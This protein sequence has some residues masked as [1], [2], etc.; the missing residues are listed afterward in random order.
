[1]IGKIFERRTAFRAAAIIT[2][3][4]VLVAAG[5]AITGLFA[6]AAILPPGSAPT[7]ASALFALYAATRTLPLA[8]FALVAIFLRAIPALLILGGLAGLVQFLDAGVGLVQGDVGKTVGPLLIAVL[9]MGTVWNLSRAK[10]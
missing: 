7:S 1:L 4:N 9:Q 3:L 8:V 6:P 10:D 5:F 2:A